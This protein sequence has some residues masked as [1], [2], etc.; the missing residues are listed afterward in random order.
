VAA[1]DFILKRRAVAKLN[2]LGLVVG[3]A[4]TALYTSQ[5][6]HKVNRL[7]LYAPVWLRQTKSLTDSGGALGAYRV[8]TQ[9]AALKRRGTG[10]P[11]GKKP[12]PDAWAEEGLVPRSRAIPSAQRKSAVRARAQRSGAGWAANT[13]SAG[14]RSTILRTSGTDDAD[15]RRVGRRHPGLHGQTLF[16]RLVNAERSAW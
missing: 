16:P 4:I 9:E 8:V 10:I 5:N 11:A 2:V 6:N 14:N 12:M 13:G 7:V 3:T 15:P 1:V